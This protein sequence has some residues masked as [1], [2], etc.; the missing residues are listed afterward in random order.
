MS[1]ALFVIGKVKSFR[2]H[3][4]LIF[5][6]L[7]PLKTMKLRQLKL[8]VGFVVLKKRNLSQYLGVVSCCSY[9]NL[10]LD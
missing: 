6:N 5:A 8:L 7:A 1:G 2:E 10:P 3:G 4:H 9:S